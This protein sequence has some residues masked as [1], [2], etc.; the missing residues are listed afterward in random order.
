MVDLDVFW[1]E[2]FSQELDTSYRPGIADIQRRGLAIVDGLLG[3]LNIS[4]GS[5]APDNF[6]LVI[7]KLAQEARIYGVLHYNFEAALE[8]WIEESDD[9]NPKSPT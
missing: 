7:M 9:A 4:Y 2:V 5:P 1:P 6:G 3:W 8:E